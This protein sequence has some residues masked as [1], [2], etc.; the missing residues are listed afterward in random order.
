MT[1]QNVLEPRIDTCIMN[2]SGFTYL[3]C[4]LFT[5]NYY[6]PFIS[7]GTDIRILIIGTGHR[8]TYRNRLF[9]VNI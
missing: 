6:N 3:I 2:N 1:L 4:I 9:I 5:D 8:Y 7:A